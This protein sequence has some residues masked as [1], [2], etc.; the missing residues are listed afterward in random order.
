MELRAKRAPVG[1]PELAPVAN[2][3]GANLGPT[4]E[5]CLGYYMNIMMPFDSRASSGYM[6]CVA[7]SIVNTFYANGI[8]AH[9]DGVVQIHIMY[10]DDPIV[11]A[12]H[13]RQLG[14]SN[15]LPVR[16]TWPP[17]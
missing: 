14:P 10:L 6:Q 3:V 16:R 11:V 15:A 17:N 13:T 9:N 12:L 5:C 7:D 2:T 4:W 1:Q 8:H